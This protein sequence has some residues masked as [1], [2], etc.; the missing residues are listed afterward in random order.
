MVRFYGIAAW[1]FS[2]LSVALLVCSL[3]L[4]PQN[5]VLAAEGGGCSGDICNNPNKDCIKATAGTC[6][7]NDAAVRC[8]NTTPGNDCSACTCQEPP[9]GSTRKTCRCAQ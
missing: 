7:F 6:T 2:S 9:V 8:N 4:A 1:L 3:M 5:R